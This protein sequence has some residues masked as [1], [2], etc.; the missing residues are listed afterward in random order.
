MGLGLIQGA[1]TGFLV[2]IPYVGIPCSAL[3]SVAWGE[4]EGTGT[5]L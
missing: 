1:R 5:S 3:I 4:R 2:P